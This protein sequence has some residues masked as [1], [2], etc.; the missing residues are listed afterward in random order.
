MRAGDSNGAAHGE[1]RARIRPILAGTTL[2]ATRIRA[3]TIRAM[4]DSMAATI[5]GMGIAG[6]KSQPA[7]LEKRAKTA[8]VCFWQGITAADWESCLFRE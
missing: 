4:W 1:W 6:G 5:G 7:E 8:G 3:T 2:L